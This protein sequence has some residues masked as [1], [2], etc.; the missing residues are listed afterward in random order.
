[1]GFGPEDFQPAGVPF[2]RVVVV[3]N[4]RVGPGECIASP[5]SGYWG[6]KEQKSKWFHGLA[7]AFLR[8]GARSVIASHWRVDDRTTADLMQRFYERLADGASKAD[9]L[10]QAK[11]ILLDSSPPRDWASFVLIGDGAAVV[12]LLRRERWS[13][14]AL[15]VVVAAIVAGGITAWLVGRRAL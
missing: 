13:G 15:L 7:R 6:R 10:R 2:S 11:L 4:T 8:A 3:G 9:A 5:A 1:M 14:T 12:P